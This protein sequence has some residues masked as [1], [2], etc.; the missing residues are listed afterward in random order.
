LQAE[1]IRNRLA[2]F[3]EFTHFELEE[4]AELWR[5]AQKMS[6]AASV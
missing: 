3:K 2:Q 1:E 4:T 5:K 6:T